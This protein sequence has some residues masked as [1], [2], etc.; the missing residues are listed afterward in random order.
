MIKREKPNT[1]GKS[2]L[3]LGIAAAVFVFGIGFCGVLGASQGWLA[4]AAIPLLVC[5][6]TS[7]FLGLVG[8]VLGLIGLLTK[9]VSRAT[10]VSGVLLSAISIF[11]FLAFLN[12]IGQ[13]A[14]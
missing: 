3:G 2:S 5:G 7:A 13:A 14:G 6:A 9:E 1:L 10:A 12:A 11:L 4:L 8:F